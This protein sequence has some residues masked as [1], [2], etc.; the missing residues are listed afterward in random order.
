MQRP[1]DTVLAETPVLKPPEG[2]NSQF[3]NPPNEFKA[4]SIATYTIC[5]FAATIAIL[6][7]IYTKQWVIHA[8]QLEDRKLNDILVHDLY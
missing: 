7:R 6:I 1:N 8:I 5:L 2:L 3:I 4:V